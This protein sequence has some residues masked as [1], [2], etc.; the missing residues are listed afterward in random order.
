VVIAFVDEHRD[1]FGVAPIC[2]V[3]SEH[4]V[5][6]APNSYY[7]HKTRPA[8]PRSLRDGRVLAEIE[9]VHADPLLGRGLYGVR[10][11]H[12]ALGRQGGVDGAP[13]R[14]GSWSG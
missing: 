9:R 1:R 8:S 11:M 4:G 10:K 2:R 12:A 3:L 5:P 6:I 13:G 7:A 14:G